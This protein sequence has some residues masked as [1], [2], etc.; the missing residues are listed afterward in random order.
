MNWKELFSPMAIPIV[1]FLCLGIY[2]IRECIRSYRSPEFKADME[3]FRE[4][5]RRKKAARRS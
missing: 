5:R 4:Q 3:R 2:F 1:F